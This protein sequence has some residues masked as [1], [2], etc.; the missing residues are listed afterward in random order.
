MS[1]IKWLSAL[2]AALIVLVPSAPEPKTTFAEHVAPIIYRRCT[3]C[4][5]AGE[6]A[7]FTL[8]SFQDAKKRAATIAE[9]T[10]KRQMPPWRAVS[11]YNE[12]HDENRLSDSELRTL[13]KWV[14]DGVL[15]G[16]AK[17]EPAAPTF[18]SGWRLGEPDVVISADRP[19][20]LAADGEDVYRNFIIKTDYKETRWVAGMDVRPGN[21]KVVHHVIAYLDETGTSEKLEA[22]T[23]DGQ[24][25]F[26]TFDS[27][28][29]APSGSLGGWAP[30]F[31]PRFTPSGTAFALKPGTRIVLQV[32]YHKTGKE[33]T[34][35][36][37]VALY[38]AKQKPEQEIR[39]AWIAN[40]VFRLIPGEK[41]QKVEVNLPIPASV[42]TYGAMPH[43][44]LL[45]RSMKAW[46]V[47]PDGSTRPMVWVD[48][49]D[50]NWQLIYA[51]KEPL[52]I[53]KGSTIHVEAVYDN[54]ADNP[55]NP[56]NPPKTVR[57]GEQTT[58]EMMLLIVPFTVDG[59]TIDSPSRLRLGFGG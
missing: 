34:D 53:P 39:L 51:F 5:R 58:D 27:T 24:P 56:N 25:G 14:S 30:G 44:H 52:R 32:H 59:A 21:P 16:D 40:P 46:V 20:K 22:K 42:T 9:V 17:K 4:H 3:P 18:A 33:E 54:S 15:R 49:W 36:T 19:Y 26:S 12:F 43:M 37:R 50:F 57:W 8:T 41:A 23:S 55:N 11:G 1:L 28:R 29:F 45:G 6:V 48:D 47:L 7:P 38:F 10:G 31:Q 2:C 35:L 13:Q